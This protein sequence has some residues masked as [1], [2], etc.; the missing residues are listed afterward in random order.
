MRRYLIL[1]VGVL[2][3][4]LAI[5]AQTVNLENWFQEELFGFVV[6][7]PEDWI[8]QRPSELT[9]VFSGQPGTAAYHATVTIQNVA[10]TRIGGVFE[11]VMSV[12]N[13]YKC[14]LTSA[15]AEIYIYDHET[16]VWPLENGKEL[17]GIG[18]KA[19]YPFQGDV[20]KT[21]QVIFPHP[22]GNIFCS[23]AYSAPEEYYDDY[24]DIVYAMFDSWEFTTGTP[25]PEIP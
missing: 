9:V 8:Y 21:S 6:A 19:E 3:L 24:V 7:Y 13:D 25:I 2:V 12:V 18:F 22:N 20:F 17:S 10:S 15:V 16:W 1:A 11:D 4:S 14:Q 23:W 5:Q